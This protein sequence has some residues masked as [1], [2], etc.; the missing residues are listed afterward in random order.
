MAVLTWR[1][2]FERKGIE[3]LD[4]DNFSSYWKDY[5]NTSKG[6]GT[7]KH[8]D[9]RSNQVLPPLYGSFTNLFTQMQAEYQRIYSE[10][11]NGAEDDK[12]AEAA[13]KVSIE[14]LNSQVFGWHLSG[15]SIEH[16]AAY[17]ITASNIVSMLEAPMPT[18]LKG[19]P[20]TYYWSLKD[21]AHEGVHFVSTKKG[22][23]LV[24]DQDI[25]DGIEGPGSGRLE[26]NSKI[27][28]ALSELLPEEA[29]PEDLEQKDEDSESVPKSS[30]A[31]HGRSRSEFE[32]ICTTKT[33]DLLAASAANGNNP[34]YFTNQTNGFVIL[35]D[36]IK[37][38]ADV[39]MLNRLT[40]HKG[41]DGKQKFQISIY[42]KVGE[43]LSGEISPSIA[44]IDEATVSR[45]DELLSTAT[46]LARRT[47]GCV[48]LITDRDI[49]RGYSKDRLPKGLFIR[50]QEGEVLLQAV[51]LHLLD[52]FYDYDSAKDYARQSNFEAIIAILPAIDSEAF[53]KFITDLSEKYRISETVGTQA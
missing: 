40:E 4:P 46:D 12:K 47:R 35:G 9:A 17:G 43:G 27:V 50:S 44:Y 13:A 14:E 33:D 31:G 3:D 2:I 19:L 29:L 25:E 53:D 38:T 11:A 42:G 24:L 51:L 7:E 1:E 48:G 32:A 23:Y 22:I 6:A 34:L 37:T 36:L 8:F 16:L 18:P 45:A 10:R 28:E 49:C 30:S 15:M 21:K 26:S 39:S 20:Y 5:Y 41:R 52:I